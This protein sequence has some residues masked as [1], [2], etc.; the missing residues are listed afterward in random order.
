MKDERA[1]QRVIRE[2]KEDGDDPREDK[3]RNLVRS[4]IS[5]ASLLNQVPQ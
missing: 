2:R 1:Q 3:A 4:K 5:N